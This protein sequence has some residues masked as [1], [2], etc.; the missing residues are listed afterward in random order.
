MEAYFF[1]EIRLF[2]FVPCAGFEK[3]VFHS[4][5]P[6]AHQHLRSIICYGRASVFPATGF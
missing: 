1:I 2:I 3:E 4:Y 6:A 5:Y